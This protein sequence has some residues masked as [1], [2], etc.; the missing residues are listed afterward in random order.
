L[1]DHDDIKNELVK[2]HDALP[3][4][5]KTSIAK[6]DDPAP[7]QILYSMSFNQEALD[8]LKDDKDFLEHVKEQEKS[9]NQ[10]V[11]IAAK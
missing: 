10:D 6:V 5:I 2:N 11:Q 8:G 3:T 1:V 9:D 4:I 7:M